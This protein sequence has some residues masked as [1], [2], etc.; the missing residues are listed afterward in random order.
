MTDLSSRL[1]RLSNLP[2]LGVIGAGLS[3]VQE[4]EIQRA[5]VDAAEALE[6]FASQQGE[7][8]LLATTASPGRLEKGDGAPPCIVPTGHEFGRTGMVGDDG[9]LIYDGRKL[10]I[11]CGEEGGA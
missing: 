4:R 9:R 11:H 2:G 8:R 6:A 7:A 5:M 10:C 3:P 1:R